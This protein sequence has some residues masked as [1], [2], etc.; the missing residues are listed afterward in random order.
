MFALRI[1]ITN[2]SLATR[3]GTEVYVRDLALALAAAGHAPMVYTPEPG[4]VAAEIAAAGVPVYDRLDD[5]LPTP[6][7][8]HGQHTVP[9]LAALRRF[10]RAPG[11]YVCHDRT[12]REDAPAA[13]PRLYRHV[14]V[15]DNCRER[16][17]L[18]GVPPARVRVV[19]NA[20]DLRR[21]AP[22]APLPARPRR[23]AIFSNYAAADTQLPAV[24]AACAALGLPLDVIGAAA[25]RASRAPE[26]ELGRYDVVFAKARCAL[27]AMAVGC[28]V[29]L[30]DFGGLGAMVTRSEAPR[31]RRWNFGARVLDR[32]LQP[33]LIAAE[34]ARYD[35]AD[36]TAVS[37]WVR[38]TADLETCVA[39][40][41]ALYREAIETHRAAPPVSARREARTAA[42]ALRAAGLPSPWRAGLARVPLVG[43]M[44][45]G[46]KRALDG[47]P[48]LD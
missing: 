20:V 40:L 17:L 43:G 1:L 13:L 31:L 15:D 16:V 3:S 35:A 22:R 7:V 36:A 10:P 46:L 26:A 2:R 28:A 37:R 5:D 14:A 38:E 21:F 12:F 42:R 23:A 39:E 18:A 30:C 11:L 4:A 6:D 9:T 45:L 44:L 48:P 27:E 32:P 41:V 33:R 8:V 19:F 34:V 25:G 24:Q 29:V 47:L